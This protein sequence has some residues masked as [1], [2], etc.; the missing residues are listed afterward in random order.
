MNR[1]TATVAIAAAGVC[2]GIATLAN[3][4][5]RTN[6]TPICMDYDNGTVTFRPCPTPIDKDRFTFDLE[7]TPAEV[8][9]PMCGKRIGN[10]AYLQEPC[11]TPSRPWS[12]QHFE[13]HDE[14][15]EGGK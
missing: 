4:S 11:P 6:G 3:A 7:P 1:F 15:V 2:A 5:D 14:N 12:V 9:L 10:G 13:L 8:W